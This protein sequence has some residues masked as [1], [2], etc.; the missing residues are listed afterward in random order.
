MLATEAKRV[1]TAM[2]GAV[3]LKVVVLD[4]R[5]RLGTEA[6]RRSKQKQGP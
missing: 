6:E 4:L 3:R 5:K 1:G 2:G